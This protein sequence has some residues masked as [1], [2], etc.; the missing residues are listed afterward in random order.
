MIIID[1]INYRLIHRTNSREEVL[2]M[3]SVLEAHHIKCKVQQESIGK[4]YAVASD[5][6]G[7]TRLFVPEEDV[8]RALEILEG[9]EVGLVGEEA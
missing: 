1:S 5:G 9:M 6:L 4:I 8:E 7:E 3:Q 2:V